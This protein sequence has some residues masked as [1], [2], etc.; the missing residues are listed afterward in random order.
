LSTVAAGQPTT[1]WHEELIA[2]ARELSELLDDHPAFLDRISATVVQA[3][4]QL[5][6]EP[7]LGMDLV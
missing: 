1:S 2:E 3:R 7:A 6:L 4:D 5:R